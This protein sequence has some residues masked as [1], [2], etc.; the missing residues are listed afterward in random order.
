MSAKTN[1]PMLDL[2]RLHR[3][4]RGE[5]LAAFEEVLSSGAFIL[6]PA[7]EKFE[8]ELAEYIGVGDAIGV[9]SGTD[10]LLVSMMALGV[11]PGDEVITTPYSFFATAGSIARLGARP[12]FVDIEAD[13]FN[14]DAE[15]ISAAVTDKTVGIVPVHLFGQCADMDLILEIA[16]DRGLFVLEDAAQAIG[17]EYKGKAAGSMGDAGVFS[18]FPAKNLGGLGDGGAVVT[19]DSRLAERVRTLRKHGGA[20]KYVHEEVGG[21][22]RLDALQ[23]AFLSAKLLHLKVWE[24]GRRRMADTYDRELKGLDGLVLP[25]RVSGRRH[26]F[27]QYVI[28]TPSRDTLASNLTQRGIAHAVY[29]PL[30]L[31]LQKCFCELGYSEGDFPISEKAARQS[32]A[33][34]VDPMLERHEIDAIVEA[35]KEPLK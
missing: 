26:V 24:Q 2:V 14:I 6:G 5:L 16:R 22:F 8:N 1:I 31:H 15:K 28:R 32:L 19:N 17:A 10:G 25:R 7:V 29:Y 4:I 30:P 33:I 13:T 11:G 23:A 27:N 18:F 35:M 9:N 21:N 3:G 34:P 20:N 12:V